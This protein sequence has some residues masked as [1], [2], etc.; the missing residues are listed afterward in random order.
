MGIAQADHD[1]ETARMASVAAS[2]PVLAMKER[3]QVRMKLGVLFV[4]GRLSK[5]VPWLDH[6]PNVMK[7]RKSTV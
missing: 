3:R 6:V 1:A 7:V 2:V 5:S 4:Y